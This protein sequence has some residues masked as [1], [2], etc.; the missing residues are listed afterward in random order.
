MQVHA[1]GAW[2]RPLLQPLLTWRLLLCLV[3]P[4][5]VS[6]AT[7]QAGMRPFKSL[8]IESGETTVTGCIMETK[9]GLMTIE[10]ASSTEAAYASIICVS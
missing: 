2:T 7:K 5:L 8:F 3:L 10:A 6:A 1:K 9:L 4:V